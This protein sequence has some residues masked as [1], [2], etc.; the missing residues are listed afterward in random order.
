MSTP[1]GAGG[2][3]DQQ[4]TGQDKD[5]DA[6]HEIAITCAGTADCPANSRASGTAL[7]TG[8]PVIAAAIRAVTPDRASV[9]LATPLGMD[10]AWAVSDLLRLADV[11]T[12]GQFLTSRILPDR[13]FLHGTDV[14]TDKSL[15]VVIVISN[16]NIYNVLNVNTVCP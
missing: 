13:P 1:G 6:F 5:A 16:N 8:A 10:T 11:V 4:Q 12:A 7:T 14:L 15:R 9:P 2:A 3:G